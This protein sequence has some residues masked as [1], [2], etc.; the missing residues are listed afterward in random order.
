MSVKTIG[1]NQKVYGREVP[2]QAGS[3]CTDSVLVFLKLT[4][5]KVD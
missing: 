1:S 4:Q 2:T 5:F 3:R